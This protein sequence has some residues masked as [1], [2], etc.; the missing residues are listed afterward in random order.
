MGFR[1]YYS[2]F[3]AEWQGEGGESVGMNRSFSRKAT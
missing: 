1:K 3:Y 2:Q